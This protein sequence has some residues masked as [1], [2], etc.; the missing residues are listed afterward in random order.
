[1]RPRK[2]IALSL[3]LIC[4]VSSIAGA[5]Q[6]SVPGA[7]RCE[8]EVYASAVAEKAEKSIGAEIRN[9][10]GI[11]PLIF[12]ALNPDTRSAQFV[13]NIG[14]TTVTMIATGTTWSFVEVTDTGNV[15]VTQVFLWDEPQA[16][17]GIYRAIH[18][19]HSSLMGVI[20]ASQHYGHCKAL[21]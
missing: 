18:S 17:A 3:L 19:R 10:S 11:D 21:N 8:F 15:N 6:P 7:L 9:R 16:A 4:A 12:A 14:A 2:S 5:G 20:V 1:M 13:G